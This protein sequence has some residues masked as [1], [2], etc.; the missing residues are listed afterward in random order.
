MLRPQESGQ[1]GTEAHGWNVLAGRRVTGI[2][3]TG[4]AD[5]RCS[6]ASASTNAS[7]WSIGCGIGGSRT[8]N[9]LSAR[10]VRCP[11]RHDPSGPCGILWNTRADPTQVQGEIRDSGGSRTRVHR[12]AGGY[13]ATR[14]RRHWP[15]GPLYD[16]DGRQRMK[17]GKTVPHSPMAWRTIEMVMELSEIRADGLTAT[18]TR[19][20]DRIRTGDLR[21]MSPTRCR[22]A[23]LRIGDE[24][25]TGGQA[26]VVSSHYHSRP[27]VERSLTRTLVQ[28][29]CRLLDDDLR[30]GRCPGLFVLDPTVLG[31]SPPSGFPVERVGRAE[32]Y[33]SCS[34]ADVS[35]ILICAGQ[36]TTVML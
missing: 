24:T 18:R 16:T 17:H 27:M 14:S 26:N 21:V 11:L 32:N 19:S 2:V 22:T 13:L 8:H 33:C 25:D 31:G 20:G 34:C 7:A 1:D 12:F 9:L 6:P 15:S 3:T 10:Q 30:C 35:R 36:R 28:W 29:P 4:G 5:Y 23:P